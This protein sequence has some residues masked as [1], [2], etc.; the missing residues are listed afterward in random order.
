MLSIVELM[1]HSPLFI[2]ALLTLSTICV[3]SVHASEE[4]TIDSLIFMSPD[5]SSDILP[6]ES[7]YFSFCEY[8]GY[9]IN[10]D[11]WV[12]GEI[13]GED[14]C[15]IM[16]KF[17]E[18]GS[19][20]TICAR[21]LEIE[22]CRSFSTPNEPEVSR[23]AEYAWGSSTIASDVIVTEFSSETLTEG[24]KAPGIDFYFKLGTKND[25]RVEIDYSM[26]LDFGSSSVTLSKGS[27]S[28]NVFLKPSLVVQY[29]TD[30]SAW[31]EL[32][33]PMPTIEPVYDGQNHIM[34]GDMKVYY[35]DEFILLDETNAIEYN[36]EGNS[37][38]QEFIAT[39]SEIDLYPYL[40]EI[41][42][43]SMKGVVGVDLFFEVIDEYGEV[44]MPLIY[45][46]YFGMEGLGAYLV[47]LEPINQGFDWDLEVTCDYYTED[48]NDRDDLTE[49]SS[50]YM[51]SGAKHYP[52]PLDSFEFVFTFSD[53][54]Y[55]SAKRCNL[56]Q[57]PLGHDEIRYHVSASYQSIFYHL[58]DSAIA[59]QFNS[60]FGDAEWEL[61]GFEKID[62][63]TQISN[64]IV[65]NREYYRFSDEDGDGTRDSIDECKNTYPGGKDGYGS[66][67]SDGCPTSFLETMSYNHNIIFLR[68]YEA[69]IA[70]VPVILIIIFGLLFIRKKKTQEDDYESPN[71]MLNESIDEM[72]SS[73]EIP[74]KITPYPNFPLSG[75]SE[76]S[77]QNDQR[78][79]PPEISKGVISP[80]GYEWL[81][82]PADS[83]KHFYR[84][85]G[86]ESWEIWEN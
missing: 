46:I 82:F 16:I 26:Q 25:Y 76:I 9:S 80:D 10:P 71:K 34:F 83:G 59:V 12:N 50:P 39:L 14:T 7:V 79:S 40:Q 5:S 66:I 2:A 57:S 45:E 42:Q 33:I 31:N 20:Y 68:V 38:Q 63:L 48:P 1:K 41:V 65:T 24:M 27:S 19:D 70:I 21:Y 35:W 73:I 61:Y 62:G 44:S 17:N 4:A 30:N 11:W 58:Q 78:L 85:P 18:W 36:D 74:Q 56:I 6:F 54:G 15:E 55:G 75:V 84:I 13:V 23:L 69:E 60:N 52:A 29:S 22:P 43:S 53:I 64:V 8:D 77:L 67:G 37:F 72:Q 32:S 28:R 51:D 49:Y 86:A 81:E 47:T 3:G